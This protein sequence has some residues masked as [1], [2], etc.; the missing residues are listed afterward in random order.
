MRSPRDTT[1]VFVTTGTRST[2]E[3][4]TVVQIKLE[5]K[6]LMETPLYSWVSERGD[7]KK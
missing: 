7:W 2:I 6:D 4:K 3:K 5:I 1:G